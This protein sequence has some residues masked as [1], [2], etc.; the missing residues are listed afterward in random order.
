MYWLFL[1][2][3]DLLWT[4]IASVSWIWG[5]RSLW[6]LIDGIYLPPTSEVLQAVRSSS[7]A[8]TDSSLGLL[9]M[10][11]QGRVQH[12]IGLLEAK[13]PDVCQALVRWSLLF[14]RTAQSALQLFAKYLLWQCIWAILSPLIH[15]RKSIL[16]LLYMLTIASERMRWLNACISA[17][18]IQL[19][20]R[21][22]SIYA[23]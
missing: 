16:K 6:S 13:G 11:I 17:E 20:N 19:D 7:R 4:Q 10:K 8:E 3:L 18:T 23:I 21:C 15:R 12:A 1:S 5:R 22:I 2:S 14:S 9:Q